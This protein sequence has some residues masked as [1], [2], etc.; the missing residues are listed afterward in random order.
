MVI[1]DWADLVCKALEIVLHHWLVPS[2]NLKGWNSMITELETA[3]LPNLAEDVIRH[4]IELL[5]LD[6]QGAN[7]LK[8]N[9]KSGQ[10][11]NTSLPKLL[12]RQL[13]SRNVNELMNTIPVSFFTWL[14]L[15]CLIAKWLSTE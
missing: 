14:T 10:Y 15:L 13:I 5:K 3:R 2:N 7:K 1:N 6:E 4:E 9:L 11:L 12:H 8:D